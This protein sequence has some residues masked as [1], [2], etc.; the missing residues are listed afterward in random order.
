MTEIKVSRLG[1]VDYLIVFVLLNRYFV[2]ES[3][4]KSNASLFSA[5]LAN[6]QARQYRECEATS[7]SRIIWN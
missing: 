7:Q 4:M 5:D 1:M 6:D 2:V 3:T